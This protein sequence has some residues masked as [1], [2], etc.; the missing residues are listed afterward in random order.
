MFCVST[1]PLINMPASN[2][3]SRRE[4]TKP[5]DPLGKDALFV[6]VLLALAALLAVLWFADP[7]HQPLGGSRVDWP[8]APTSAAPDKSAPAR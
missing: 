3:G 1:S 2:P 5:V 8:A 4:V 7:A 6:I